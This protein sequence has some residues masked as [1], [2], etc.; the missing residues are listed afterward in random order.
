LNNALQRT[1]KKRGPLSAGVRW[2]KFAITMCILTAVL[3]LYAVT[4]G[5]VGLNQ[6]GRGIIT[7]VVFAVALLAFYPSRAKQGSA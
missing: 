7:D 2:V 4:Q 6:V 1:R 3:N 5:Y